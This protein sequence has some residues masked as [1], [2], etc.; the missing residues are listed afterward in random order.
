MIYGSK[1]FY[2]VFKMLATIYERLVKA[3]QLITK[4]VEEDL[5]HQEILEK[6]GMAGEDTATQR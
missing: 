5:S 2:L 6:V 4:K 1:D 3:K